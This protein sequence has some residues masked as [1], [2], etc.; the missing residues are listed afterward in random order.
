KQFSALSNPSKNYN[1]S[2]W[3]TNSLPA[4]NIIYIGLK[5]T[6]LAAG[7]TGS[8]SYSVA[9]DNS[10]QASTL[11][12]IT[13]AVLNDNLDFIYTSDTD[14]IYINALYQVWVCD[15]TGA[16]YQLTTNLS[17]PYHVQD[18]IIKLDFPDQGNIS[19]IVIQ[20]GFDAGFSSPVSY[21][22]SGGSGNWSVNLGQEMK[23]VFKSLLQDG[24][25]DILYFNFK[26]NSQ[27]RL[28]PTGNTDSSWQ[29]EVKQYREQQNRITVVNNRITAVG[30]PMGLFLEILEK[31]TVK[32][33]IYDYTGRRIKTLINDAA[34]E[35][36]SYNK[37]W[38]GLNE[39]QDYLPRGLYILC[40]TIN[41]EPAYRD[42]IIDYYP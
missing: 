19:N 37:T 25:S 16:E 13:S 2:D 7:E 8:F 42:I 12:L 14:D 28:T 21:E 6:N 11:S 32:A 4:S 33:V 10:E 30:D 36:G 29:I 35:P 22:M 41:D 31:C 1:S 5:G 23:S 39:D 24:K 15:Y 18:L 9:V 17:G 27:N 26:I 38:Y 20:A 34:V 40:V 3:S